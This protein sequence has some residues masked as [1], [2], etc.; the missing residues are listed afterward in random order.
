MAIDFT[1]IS[2]QR[3]L[4]RV[5]GKFVKEVLGEAR[6]AELLVRKSAL[7]RPSAWSASTAMIM[8]CRSHVAGHNRAAGLRRWRYGH[9]TAATAHDVQAKR[10]MI[11][12]KRGA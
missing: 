7:L 5:S 8:R 10:L 6:G 9:Q 12:C 11:R 4:Q 3:D 2:Q 1:L